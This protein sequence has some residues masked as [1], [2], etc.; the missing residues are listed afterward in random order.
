M[1][2]FL[3]HLTYSA[4]LPGRDPDPA[5]KALTVKQRSVTA[6][7]RYEVL[8]GVALKFEAQRID[9]EDDNYGLFDGKNASGEYIKD[10]RLYG[11]ALDVIF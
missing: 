3:P 8:D 4:V 9:P 10:A 7:L 1:G 11:I 2:K 6:G 5:A